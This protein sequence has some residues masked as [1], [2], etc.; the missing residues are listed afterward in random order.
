MKFILESKFTN[1]ISKKKNRILEKGGLL[2][3]EAAEF[4]KS[5]G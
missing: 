4:K 2:T 5:V 3:F 1:W